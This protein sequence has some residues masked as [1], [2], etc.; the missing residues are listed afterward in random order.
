M[1]FA[2]PAA[3][4]LIGCE[5]APELSAPVVLAY[6]AGAARI[7]G[8]W[9]GAPGPGVEVVASGTAVSSG[10]AGVTWTDGRID[11]TLPPGVRSG[12]LVVRTKSG[13]VHANLEV[14]RLEE[15]DLPVSAGTNASPLSLAR[16]G[17]GRLWINEEFH[18]QLK[19]FDP[20]GGGPP[21]AIDI[22]RPADPGPFAVFFDELFGQQN[23]DLRTQTSV[24]GESVIVDPQGFVWFSEGGGFFYELTMDGK[25]VHPNHSRIVRHDPNGGSF[26]V[27]NVPGDRNEVI[28]LAWDATRGRIWFAEGG[29][30]GGGAI[31]SFDPE[32]APWYNTFDF[33]SSLDSYVNMAD[34][35]DG[36][37]RF[38]VPDRSEYPSWLAVDADGGVWYTGFLGNRVGRLDP[39]TGTFVELPLPRRK[40]T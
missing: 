25:K 9:F 16:D 22:P 12:E 11:L 15:W 10:A 32:R 27:Y 6:E 37:R 21:A 13:E 4:A 7:E 2:L 29:R 33:T 31:T 19:T 26:R 28:G 17:L 40:S 24:L 20:N 18:N 30:Q 3:A 8:R 5:R 14:Y 1:L 23:V 39:E 36:F 38:V 35:R 34:P